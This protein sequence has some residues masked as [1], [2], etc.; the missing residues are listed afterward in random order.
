MGICELTHI[1]S[2]EE[3]IWRCYNKVKVWHTVNWAGL[4][5]VQDAIVQS[6]GYIHVEAFHIN[7]VVLHWRG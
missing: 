7:S 6:K 5:Y 2:L 3:I 1:I 4:A